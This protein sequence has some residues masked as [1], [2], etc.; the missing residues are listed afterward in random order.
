MGPPLSVWLPRFFFL[1]GRQ[2]TR[3]GF[4]VVDQS[5]PVIVNPV[6]VIVN[7]I[8]RSCLRRIGTPLCLQHLRLYRAGLRRTV[9]AIEGLRRARG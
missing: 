3:T 1:Q 5:E 4:I 9:T 8:P 6:A 7:F 2:P